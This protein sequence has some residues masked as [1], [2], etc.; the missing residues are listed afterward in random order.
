VAGIDFNLYVD[1]EMYVRWVGL[2][3]GLV[4]TKERGIRQWQ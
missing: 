3:E 2:L 4:T 1:K